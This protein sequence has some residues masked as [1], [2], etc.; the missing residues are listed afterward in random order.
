MARAIETPSLAVS[1][2]SLSE[3]T[4]GFL[5]RESTCAVFGFTDHDRLGTVTTGF[6]AARPDINFMT[7][8]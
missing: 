3:H 5:R 7:V 4:R 2:P 1:N 8:H 6:R